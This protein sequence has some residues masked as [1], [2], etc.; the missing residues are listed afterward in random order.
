MIH[1]DRL[2]I[3]AEGEVVAVRAGIR[4]HGLM[5]VDELPGLGGRGEIPFDPGIHGGVRGLIAVDG[6]EMRGPVVEGVILLG[7]VHPVGGQ[8]E[9]V[10][11]RLAVLGQD[12]VVS[13]DRVED[14]PA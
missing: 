7:T 8:V 11:E 3:R 10:Q 5:K 4:I 13:D 12:V 2:Q 9:G 14:A 1:E 6:D